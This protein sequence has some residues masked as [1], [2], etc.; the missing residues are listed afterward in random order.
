MFFRIRAGRATS[1]SRENI[2]AIH[3]V[4]TAPADRR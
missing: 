2:S 4:R 1:N 3:G